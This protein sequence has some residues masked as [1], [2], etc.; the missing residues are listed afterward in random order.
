MNPTVLADL[1]RHLARLKRRRQRFRWTMA[2]SAVA[3]GVLWALAVAFPIDWYFQRGMDLWQRLFLL[4]VVAAAIGYAFRRYS[5]PWLGRRETELDLALLV[6][7]AEQIDTD[8]VAAIEFEWPEARQWGSE[9]LQQA[10]IDQVAVK[11]R[12]I[13]VMKNLPSRDLPGRLKLLALTVVLWAIVAALLP[14]YVLTFLDRLLLGSMH[15]PTRTQIELLIINDREFDPAGFGR[16][17]IHVRYGLPVKFEARVAGELPP[18]GSANLTAVS[19]GARLD[20]AMKPIDGQPGVFTADL[21]RLVGPVACQFFFNDAWT[22]AGR[23]IASPLPVV[24]LEPQVVPPPYAVTDGPALVTIPR[25]MRQFSVIEGSLVRMKARCDKPLR[26]SV[27]TLDDKPFR[28][29]RHESSSE[30]SEVWILAEEESPLGCVVQPLRFSLQVTDVDDQQMERPI[31]GVVRIQPDL[32]PRVAAATRT[33]HVLP[34]AHPTI[35]LRATDDLAL[36]RIWLA[37]EITHGDPARGDASQGDARTAEVTVYQLAADAKPQRNIENDYAFDLTPLK[38]TKGDTLKVTVWAKDF[39]GSREG[40]SASAE[41]LTYHVTDEQGILATMSESDRHSARE[42]K[43][44][45]QRQLGIG[46]SK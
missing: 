25:G 30:T 44:M 22:D 31:E 20:V 21:P 17:S 4:A 27:L 19:N 1:H 29:S 35:Y 41:P 38:M 45:I 32:P 28:M 12:Q 9:Q 6:E 37:C 7:H 16:Q 23:L 15:Y 13:N 18:A 26:E 2:G 42:L 34:T 10:V 14:Q 5:L 39:R 8:L 40:K 43:T 46:E 36:G 33:P 3:I 11:E 24:E